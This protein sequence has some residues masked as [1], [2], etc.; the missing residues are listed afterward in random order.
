MEE[1]NRF[2]FV[3]LYSEEPEDVVRGVTLPS[4]S[5][6]WDDAMLLPLQRGFTEEPDDVV[7][8]VTLPAASSLFCADGGRDEETFFLPAFISTSKSEFREER[9]LPFKE[10]DFSEVGPPRDLPL[11]NCSCASVN[12]GDVAGVDAMKALHTFFQS[13]VEAS[14]T[15]L[16]L[17]KCW[18]SVDVF[19]NESSCSMKACLFRTSKLQASGDGRHELVIEFRRQCGDSGVFMSTFANA[20]SFFHDRFGIILRGARSEEIHPARGST[21][22]QRDEC[23]LDKRI[24]AA[25]LANAVEP[26]RDAMQLSTSPGMQAEAL[27]ALALVA[28]MDALSATTVYAALAGSQ[29]NL[30]KLAD[31]SSPALSY[32]AAR[33]AHHIS[34]NANCGFEVHVPLHLSSCVF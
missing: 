26:L 34:R 16:R 24:D 32:P 5:F 2:G 18:M 17:V 25:A 10:P 6:P 4:A 3:G 1:N 8:G 23:R 31:S 11:G 19:Q 15:K 9:E 12:L 20:K 22:D 13:R 33:L 14:I 27:T 28:S 21:A 30:A 7:R 29:T